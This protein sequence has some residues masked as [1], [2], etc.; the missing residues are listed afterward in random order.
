MA[1]AEGLLQSKDPKELAR[2]LF[3]TAGLSKD[4]LGDYLGARC[5]FSSL[6]FALR[7]PNAA[8]VERISTS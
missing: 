6:S 4:K 8:A 5:G 7:L 2:F 1:L 3:E